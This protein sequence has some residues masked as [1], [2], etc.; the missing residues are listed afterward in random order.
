MHLGCE[1]FPS[2]GVPSKC[3]LSTDSKPFCFQGFFVW[4]EMSRLGSLISSRDGLAPCKTNGSVTVGSKISSGGRVVKNSVE[5]CNALTFGKASCSES[6]LDRLMQQSAESSSLKRGCS[7]QTVERHGD[8]STSRVKPKMYTVDVLPDKSTVL[9]G[10]NTVESDH[11]HKLRHPTFDASCPRCAYLK[12]GGLWRSIATTQSDHEVCRSWLAPKPS[13]MGGKWALGCL[14]CAALYE[15]RKT[16]VCAPTRKRCYGKWQA[17]S[18]WARFRVTRLLKADQ[19]AVLSHHKYNSFHRE[20]V[21]LL[22]ELDTPIAATSELHSATTHLCN[23][24]H[25]RQA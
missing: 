21:R 11:A 1:S 23:C 14:A 3:H 10:K 24:Q 22:R 9:P 8:R 13:H 6:R 16:R 25:P 5:P 4:R 2:D 19:K 7:S 12:Y 15:R 18:N 17:S 20:A